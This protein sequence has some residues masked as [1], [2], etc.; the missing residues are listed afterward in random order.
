[1][2]NVSFR[3]S[4]KDDKWF[5][6][7]FPGWFDAIGSGGSV[8]KRNAIKIGT[9]YI[10][11]NILGETF[12]SLPFDVKQDTSKGRI[13]RKD[14]PVY[15]LIHDRPNPYTNAYDFWSTIVKLIKGWGNAYARIQFQKGVPVAIWQL[16]PS[17]VDILMTES[18][19][20][21]K[22][23]S[24][25]KTYPYTE[26]LHFKNFSLD[27]IVGLSAI[28]ENRIT[29]GHAKKLKEY[30]SSLVGNR[31][32]GYLTAPTAPKDITQKEN[33]KAQWTGVNK[34]GVEMVGD[35]PLLYG[36]L[37]FKALT[38]PA[39]AVAYIESTDLSEQEICG[40]F[41]IPPTLAQNYKRATFSNAE[42]QDLVFSKYSLAMRTGMEQECNA[43][44]FR[45]DNYDSQEPLYTKFNLKG[46][47]AGDLKTRKEFYQ[48]GLTLGLFSQN[49]VL[50]LE[51]MEGF[52]G[53]DRRYIQGAMVP[54]DL[55]DEFVKK[56]K[57]TTTEQQPK[58]A[59]S[60]EQRK[61]LRSILNGHY[62]DVIDILE[63]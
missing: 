2:A 18:G 3:G 36:G 22:V 9:V 11:L 43:K 46:L 54:L 35:V 28:D 57:T 10:C 40:I 24:T 32:H 52:E 1:M 31:P 30:N 26:I 13:T 37:E 20:F 51:D 55:L 6:E 56:G 49:Q 12:G 14:S 50:A 39:D 47:L 17:D 59:I 44:L 7:N 34:T 58:E 19:L 23:K 53:G 5:Q 42:Q 45:S 16:H 25:G 4:L 41:R 63:S 33:M 27:G 60:D 8:S 48:M 21:Y 29:M 62:Q 15:K 38:L 61:Q